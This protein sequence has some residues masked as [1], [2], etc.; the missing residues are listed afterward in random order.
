MSPQKEKT[1]ARD[2]YNLIF[3]E[4]LQSIGSKWTADKKISAEIL[5]M[6]ILN[7]MIFLHK[8]KGKLIKN[9]CY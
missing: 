8:Q 3:G 5:L 6:I 2:S 1:T 9:I 7:I 4:G